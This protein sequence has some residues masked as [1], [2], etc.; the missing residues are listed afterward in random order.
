M[1]FRKTSRSHSGHYIIIISNKHGQNNARFNLTVIDKPDSPVNLIL[2][3]VTSSSATLTWEEPKEDGGS[4]ITH[5]LVEKRD[6]KRKMWQ[7]VADKLEETEMT[8]CS[9]PIVIDVSYEFI[10]ER[11]VSHSLD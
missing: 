7:T 1:L 4:P 6:V 8:V 11:V 10:Y 5:F 3:N 9:K 2:T